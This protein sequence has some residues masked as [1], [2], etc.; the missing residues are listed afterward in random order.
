[1]QAGNVTNLFISVN[2]LMLPE[3][4]F[5]IVISIISRAISK[6]WNFVTV[7]AR[8]DLFVYRGAKCKNNLSLLESSYL[9][10]SSIYIYISTSACQ[11]DVACLVCCLF[12]ITTHS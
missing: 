5:V 1:M 10:R 9:L 4:S 12:S 7:L 8:C 11:M 2:Q 3:I 6:A